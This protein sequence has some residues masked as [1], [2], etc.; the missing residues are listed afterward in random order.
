MKKKLVKMGIA[1]C[2]VWIGIFF[3]SFWGGEE[4]PFYLRAFA[5]F[6]M[7]TVGVLGYYSI[8]G[9]VKREKTEFTTPMIS[10]RKCG[11]FG[12]GSGICPRCGWGSAD[13]IAPYTKMISCQKCGYIGAGSEGYCPKCGWNRIKRI[14]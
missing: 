4:M 11:Y 13:K 8:D 6:F 14:K 1:L 2:I 7:A 3:L 10:C 12:A 9:P 5:T